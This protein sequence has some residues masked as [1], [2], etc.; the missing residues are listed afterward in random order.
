MRG[1]SRT[2]LGQRTPIN[3]KEMADPAA[4]SKQKRCQATQ[5][6]EKDV[7]IV[8]WPEPPQPEDFNDDPVD[9]CD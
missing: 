6:K 5:G 8:I 3:E 4:L 1:Y 9:D 2:E 7:N